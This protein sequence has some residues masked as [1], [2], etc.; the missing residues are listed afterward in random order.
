MKGLNLFFSL[1]F[2]CFSLAGADVKRTASGKQDLSGFYDT[3]TLTPLERPEF[4]GDTEYLYKW[5][6]D[7][8]NWAAD[9][10]C[11]FAFE[12]T[13][14]P[15]RDAPP[16]GGDGNNIAGAG[17]VGGY[18]A[19]YIDPGNRIT[20]IDGKIRTSLIYDP[21][22]GRLPFMSGEA[23]RRMAETYKSFSHDNTGT[24]SWLENVGDG[25]FDGPEALAPSERC[26]IS[27]GATVPIIL[28]LYTILRESFKLR[29][30]S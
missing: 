29:I 27:F 23:K 25:P 2:L 14:D 18:N 7:L 10:A 4:L 15:G 28:S 6:A 1:V 22:S 8:I 3:G 17:G 12:S 30:T 21:P 26:L 16:E 5:I 24:A 20:E 19:F 11:D 13:S 9:W